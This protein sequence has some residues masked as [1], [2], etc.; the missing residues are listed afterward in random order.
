MKLPS[1]FV[2]PVDR[3]IN[4]NKEVFYEEESV[5]KDLDELKNSFDE[6]GYANKLLVSIK[7]SEG[8]NDYKLILCK[9]NYFVDINDKKIYFSDIL[10][11][12]IKK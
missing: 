9:S 5:K 8:V 2:N 6:T 4:N 10:D 1:V 12:E 3:K 7:T 11:Y